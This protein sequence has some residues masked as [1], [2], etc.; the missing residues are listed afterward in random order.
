MLT[1]LRT[2]VRSLADRGISRLPSAVVLAYH[3]VCD[4]DRDPHRLCVSPSR[5]EQQ[6]AALRRVGKPVSLDDL[7]R[8]MAI[9]EL[10]GR[11]VAVTFDDGYAD[12]LHV[13]APIL[14]RH[15]VPATVFVTTAG[16]ETGEPFYWDELYELVMG[17][18]AGAQV[19]SAGAQGVATGASPGLS[20]E[21]G[22]VSRVWGAG[23]PSEELYGALSALCRPL[24]SDYR[25]EVLT[26]VRAQLDGEA[27][28]GKRAGVAEAGKP[29][30]LDWARRLSAQEVRELSGRPGI[31]IGA[32]GH[33]HLL[34]RPHTQCAQWRDIVQ[35]KTALEAI[36][37]RGVDL[38]AYAFGGENDIS[39]R[40]PRLVHDAGFI[41]A[42]VNTRG[43]AWRGADP[44]RLP[45]QLVRDWDGAE[46][47][48][49]LI[50]WFDGRLGRGV[51][52]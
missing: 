26:Q 34:Y 12:N 18:W 49:R 21:V 7:V 3:R 20:I 29:V 38:F 46:F 17:E 33:E 1:R 5:F 16:L 4:S 47:E 10:P 8:G 2:S 28:N 25:A 52:A 32:H 22:G 40:A 23:T 35:S 45:R 15:G 9:G 43:L 50:D 13:A 6:L 27:G 42:V 41:A 48:R 44:Y 19:G 24:G 14:E 31:T 11:G 39:P 51:A 30:T 37:D 36:V